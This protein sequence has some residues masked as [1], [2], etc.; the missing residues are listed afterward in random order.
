VKKQTGYL[1]GS[2]TF[3]VT[4]IIMFGLRFATSIVVARTL[5]VEGKG[6]Y[7]LVLTVSALLLLGLNLGVS[8][9]FTYYTASNQFKPS[10][11]FAFALFLSLAISAAGGAI[12]W[13][14]YRLFLQGTFLVGTL[15][16][17]ML[18]VIIS[19]PISLLT[20]FLASI[21]LGLQQIVAY[22]A[23][24]LIN[25][26]TNLLFQ[27]ASA[28]LHGGVSG[29]ILAWLASSGLA[30]LATLYLSRHFA[31]LNFRGVGKVLRPSFSYGLKN[32]VANL[33]TF[34][35]YRLDSFL[36]NFI[37]G[38]D[39]VG[40]YTTGV[41]MAELLWY[42]PNSLS[43]TLFPKVSSLDETVATRITA[44]SSR[45]TLLVS[46]PLALMFGAAGI[47]LI[48]FFY[49]AAFA[50]AVAPFL[51]LLPGILSMAVSKIISAHL[52][53]RGKP[54]Y[55]TYTSGITV[56]VTV[57]LDLIL[58]P[59]RGIVGAAIASSIAYT[60]SAVLSVIWF[61]HENQT[62]WKQVLIPTLADL[63]SLL[64]QLEKL[65]N[66]SRIKVLGAL[67]HSQE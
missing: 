13:L 23:I 59:S 41:T 33:F 15:P 65:I 26:G 61:N 10:D 40:L 32:Y 42:I 37:L 60:A 53:G 30:L 17:Q 27:V 16:N 34:F 39:S 24:N 8:G 48:P 9:A 45:Q 55:A 67:K 52:S 50:P 21:L 11:L 6:I 56:V 3:F 28:L 29:A 46:L 1:V 14:A 66:Q 35:N 19:L 38:P 44:Q 18:L 62:T 12:F 58:I 54:Q 25:Y 31:T 7:V 22:N 63:T 20:T 43:S 47:I 2:A 49:G 4:S 64:Q 51:W 57:I 5:G 36:V